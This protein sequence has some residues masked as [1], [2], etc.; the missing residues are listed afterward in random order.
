MLGE[1]L[2]SALPTSK[3]MHLFVGSPFKAYTWVVANFT[4]GNT[5]FY[6]FILLSSFYFLKSSLDM[7]S[8]YIFTHG[9]HKSNGNFKK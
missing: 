2:G 4:M 3:C 6:F 9:N 5:T 8:P 1:W 7:W